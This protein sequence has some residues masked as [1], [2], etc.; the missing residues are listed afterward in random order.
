MASTCSK[1]NRR[2]RIGQMRLSFPVR[3]FWKGSVRD[4]ACLD[5]LVLGSPLVATVFS[6]EHQSNLNDLRQSSW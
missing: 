6:K 5:Q 2:F 1:S 3:C 4:S